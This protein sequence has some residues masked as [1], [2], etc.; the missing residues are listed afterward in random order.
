MFESIIL[1]AFVIGLISALSLP[2][3][4]VTTFFWSPSDR[5]IAVLMAFGGGALLAALTIDLVASALEKGHFNSLAIGAVCGGL[6]FVGLNHI[7]NDYGGFLR[8]VSTTVYHLRHKQHQWL[9]RISKHLHRVDLFSA[10]KGSDYRMLAAAIRSIEVNKGSWIYQ[11]G[12]PSDNLYIVMSGDMAVH[13]TGR[14]SRV[15]GHRRQHDRHA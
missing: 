8:K 4:A 15:S 1:T 3:G 2:M 11:C 13:H 9:K 7:V 5:T 6:L 12:D 10:L 14:H